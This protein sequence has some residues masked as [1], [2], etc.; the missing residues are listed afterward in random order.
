MFDKVVKKLIKDVRDKRCF[1][2][3]VKD[4]TEACG[5]SCRNCKNKERCVNSDESPF[6]K[7]CK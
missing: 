7:K 6:C 1:C 2:Y 4:K 3:G 5:C